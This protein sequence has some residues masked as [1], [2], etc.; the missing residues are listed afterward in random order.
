MKDYFLWE[1]VPLDWAPKPSDGSKPESDRSR[2]HP[3]CGYSKVAYQ[4]W[5]RKNVTQRG[6]HWARL[7]VASLLR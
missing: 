5:R 7:F 2:S 4:N 3:E 6:Q 1:T